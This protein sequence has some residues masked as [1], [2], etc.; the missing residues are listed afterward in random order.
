MSAWA[1]LPR[2]LSNWTPP[3]P[4]VL[5]AP[6]GCPP[7]RTGRSGPLGAKLAQHPAPSQGR[8]LGTSEEQSLSSPRHQ[9]APSP[10]ASWCPATR[11]R[12]HHSWVFRTEGL[13]EGS[14]GD[15]STSGHIMEGRGARTA[16][17]WAPHTLEATPSP[18]WAGGQQYPQGPGS[19]ILRTS[20]FPCGPAEPPKSFMAER[21]GGE[22]NSGCAPQTP[23]CKAMLAPWCQ[24][25]APTFGPPGLLWRRWGTKP[26]PG[27]SR[28]RPDGRVSDAAVPRSPCVQG[29]DTHCFIPAKDEARVLVGSAR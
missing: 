25:L 21:P 29:A 23:P 2:T 27:D 15:T 11:T 22:E 18:E 8:F 5:L 17:R 20:P 4:A 13:E 16:S 10:G 28:R 1:H 7:S 6:R 9:E 3:C 14:L 12:S 24:R 19:P 26:F